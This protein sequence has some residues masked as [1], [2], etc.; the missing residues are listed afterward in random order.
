MGERDATSTIPSDESGRSRSEKYLRFAA[1]G[2]LGAL[3]LFALVGLFGV[4]TTTE[5]A[6]GNG[7]VVDVLH[8]SVAR[9]GLAAP[10]SVEV[11]S[12]DGSPLPQR[13]TVRVDS[14]YLAMFDDNGMEPS[15]EASYNTSEST[16]WTFEVPS[17]SS[18]LRVDL[19]ARI[20]RKH[21]GCG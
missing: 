3:V 16:W 10:F 21:A 18:S 9:P 8:A 12:D 13:V 11:R 20:D 15:P 5:T 4:R 14:T 1:F 17:G 2:L 19:D 7:F 6:R